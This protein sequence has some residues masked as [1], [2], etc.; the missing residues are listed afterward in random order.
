MPKYRV[1]IP[2]V[3]TVEVEVDAEDKD[4]AIELASKMIE[5]DTFPNT[6]GYTLSREDWTIEEIGK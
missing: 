5:V 4:H 1:A 2:E 6:Y 3:Y